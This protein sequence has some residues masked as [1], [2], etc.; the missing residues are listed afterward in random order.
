MRTDFLSLINKLKSGGNLKLINLPDFFGNINITEPGSFAFSLGKREQ[1]RQIAL[2]SNEIVTN[3]KNGQVF[4]DENKKVGSANTIV[5]KD[6]GRFF[7]Y[8]NFETSNKIESG[9]KSNAMEL[10][11]YKHMHNLFKSMDI[12][13]ETLQ[14]FDAS[15]VSVKT[16]NGKSTG[17]VK[18]IICIEKQ[19]KSKTN[20]FAIGS[21]SSGQKCYWI[22]SNFTNHMRKVHLISKSKLHDFKKKTINELLVDN[23]TEEHT[24]P[25]KEDDRPNKIQVAELSKSEASELKNS[26][27]TDTNNSETDESIGKAE[28]KTVMLEIS[29]INE[30]RRT[31]LK[32]TIYMQ[33]ANQL[34]A[35]EYCS[36][37]KTEASQDMHFYCEDQR[38]E[39]QTI[40]IPKDGNCMY[41]A[42]LHQL[43]GENVD[44]QKQ[45]ESIMR[46]RSE[47]ASFIDKNFSNFRKDLMGRVYDKFSDHS[48]IENMEDE[49]RNIIKSLSEN[50]V[51]GGSE[52]LNAISLIYEA[53]I[54]VIN[55]EGDFYFVNGF[56]ES[57]GKT[58]ILAFKLANSMKKELK[59]ISNVHRNHYESI[60]K[61]NSDII[62]SLARKSAL[63]IEK[64]C[65]MLD[66]IICV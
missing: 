42:I 52:S 59:N 66:E 44:G 18:C 54:L 20:E 5:Y 34:L 62:F 32:S 30:L 63:I 11:L 40:D 24:A 1:I 10:S 53:N 25:C 27:A 23:S 39:I 22:T 35:L 56:N 9:E 37:F 50:G 43:T 16:K 13:E 48:N 64:Q 28:M 21:K 65:E 29:T 15:I 61:I 19:F 2:Y 26:A 3:A 49:C 46:L 7:S 41:H 58:I 14:K 57:F 38:L 33:I 55:E 8:R 17:Y 31:D 4:F 51:W 47:V 36:S 6:L 60:V 12:E 45:V